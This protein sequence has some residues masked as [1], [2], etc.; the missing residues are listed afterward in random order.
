MD[1]KLSE[2]QELLLESVRAV[3][4]KF[5][6]SYFK[7]CDDEHKHPY[8]WKDALMKSGLS[9]L[10]VPEEYGGTPASYLT[11][12]LVVMELA[13]M[14]GTTPGLISL[15]VH[16]M[17]SFG[18]K[19][20][21]K[22]T[23]D[24]IGQGKN[25][26]SLGFTE[27]QAGS[28]NSAL[29][30]NYKR[31]NGKV[32]INGQKTFITWAQESPYCMA[33]TRNA[34]ATEP[35]KA[36]TLWMINMSKPGVT[37][38]PLHKI[39]MFGTSNCEIFFRDVEV[40][41]KDMVGKEGMGFYHLMDNFEV[42]RLA[43]AAGAAGQGW[44][45]FEDAAKYSSQRKQF[46]QPIGSFQLIQEKLVDMMIKVENMRNYVSKL[47]CDADAGL[48]LRL[49]NALVKRYCAKTSFEVVDDAMQVF[50]GIGYTAE[51][52]VSRVWRDARV[53]R[54]GGGTDEIMVYIAGRQIV[55][56]YEGK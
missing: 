55:K 51:T 8:E 25:P 41:E 49:S 16:N 12:M 28:D 29:T 5:P 42:E 36:F 34:D 4:K 52:R 2:E 37:I 44:C 46:G 21:L 35:G 33:M 43:A 10:G 30:T 56:M 13:R 48:S 9:M 32:Y 11:Q 31:K 26:F 23:V 17:M 3:M 14:S 1:F 15:L 50:G 40:E 20:Q 6:E 27:P 53:N 22:M 39:G 45:A 47:A 54:L 7:K 38:S 24:L 19:E 18:S